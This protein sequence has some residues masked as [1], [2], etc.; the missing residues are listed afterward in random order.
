MSVKLLNAL[1]CEEFGVKVGFLLPSR[2]LRRV[3]KHRPEVRG[4]EKS[5]AEGGLSEGAI[6]D[7]VSTCMSDLRRGERFPHDLALA[8]LAVALENRQTALAKAYLRDL[9][10]LKL[11]EMT[12]SIRVARECLEHS[13][14][15]AETIVSSYN[16]EES[17]H[18]IPPRGQVLTPASAASNGLQYRVNKDSCDRLVLHGVG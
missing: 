3:L 15:H 12:T 18:P 16:A 7:F 2:A 1:T 14:Q 13:R 17:S 11:A 10:R 9:S 5:L 8:A 6:R 4:I